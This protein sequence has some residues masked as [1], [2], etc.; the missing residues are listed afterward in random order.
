MCNKIEHIDNT[1]LVV[2]SM[3]NLLSLRVSTITPPLSSPL[4]PLVVF[5]NSLSLHALYIIKLFIYPKKIFI[6]HSN[7]IIYFCLT[8]FSLSE[9]RHLLH[10]SVLQFI[11][12]ISLMLR[13]CKQFLNFLYHSAIFICMSNKK[14]YET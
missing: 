13:F 8:L 10:P 7:Y 5:M 2:T 14:W 4:Y 9:F 11:K 12:S 1:R 6:S 3:T